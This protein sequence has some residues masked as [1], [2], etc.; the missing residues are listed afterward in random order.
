MKRRKSIQH[1][2]EHGCKF[3]R[4]GRRHTVY[5]NPSNRK[6][7]TVPR[8]NEIVGALARKICKDLEVPPSK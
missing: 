2:E 7:S 8:H 1:L 4:E 3:L 5:Y 6:T